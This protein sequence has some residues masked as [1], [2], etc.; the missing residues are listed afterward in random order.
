MYY[1]NTHLDDAS[2]CKN[3]V[4]LDIPDLRKIGNDKHDVAQNTVFS[5]AR[6]NTCILNNIKRD[7]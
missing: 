4:I 6:C 5:P 2:I 7:I 1:D 3:K